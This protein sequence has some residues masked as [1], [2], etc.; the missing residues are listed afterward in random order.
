MLPTLSAPTRINTAGTARGTKV[1][2]QAFVAAKQSGDR[3]DCRCIDAEQVAR[4][5]TCSHQFAGDWC[6]Y[7][8]IVVRREVNRRET[9][10]YV[11]FGFF[12]IGREQ[13]TQRIVDALGLEDAVA[14]DRA[15]EADG[16][17]GGRHD[18][19]IVIV[20]RARVVG[21]FTNE[22]IVERRKVARHIEFHFFEINV[23]CA[24][25]FC[26]EEVLGSACGEFAQSARST[27]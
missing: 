10:I 12:C 2:D 21:E 15:G 25:E 18:G 8:M 13:V 23:E 16:A 5:V 4:Y 3:W 22:E 14:T 27:L 6:M 1:H 24:G 11:T 19:V 9:A 26:D 7:A 17:V 20:D